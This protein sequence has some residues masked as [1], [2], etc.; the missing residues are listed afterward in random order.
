MRKLEHDPDNVPDDVTPEQIE[1][2]YDSPPLPYRETVDNDDYLGITFVAAPPATPVEALEAAARADDAGMF[3][4]AGMCLRTQRG[5][6]NVAALWPNA[7]AARLHSAPSHKVAPSHH[8]P[9]GTVG[10]AA[11]HVWLNLGAGLVRTTDFHRTGM[12]DVALESRMLEWCGTEGHIWGEVLN[13]VDVHPSRKPHPTPAHEWT[14]A[15]RADF[16][17]D[18]IREALDAG[19]TSEALQLKAWRQRILQRLAHH[20]ATHRN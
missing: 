8:A 9:R 13:G 11:N 7:R 4:G 16:L 14:P 3:F 6:W 19:R 5:F 1:R 12:V 18:E 10:F 2:A 17:R 20:A 15:E